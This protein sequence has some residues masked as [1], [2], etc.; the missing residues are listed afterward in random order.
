MNENPKNYARVILRKR[1][2]NCCVNFVACTKKMFSEEDLSGRNSSVKERL[3][4]EFGSDFPI[5][6]FSKKTLNVRLVL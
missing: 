5:L 6:N 2:V 1:S 3:E 4:A